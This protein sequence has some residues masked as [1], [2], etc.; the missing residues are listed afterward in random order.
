MD[1]DPT[2]TA[3]HPPLF[4][5]GFPWWAVMVLFMLVTGYFQNWVRNQFY[6]Y[7]SEL[8]AVAAEFAG[9]T[10]ADRTAWWAEHRAEQP[11]RYREMH[12]GAQAILDTWTLERIV[13]L[14]YALIFAFIGMF[15]ICDALFLR[16]CNARKQ[17]PF[18]KIIYVLVGATLF[19]L[20][21]LKAKYPGAHNLDGGLLPFLMS[22]MPSFVLVLF[23]WLL[24]RTHGK[25]I[26]SRT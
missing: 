20:T 19:F 25:E 18:L 16:V 17:I 10:D 11:F 8:P 13:V 6:W 14:D 22:P 21:I 15:F 24:R 1:S 9:W 12:A 2:R 3:P 4:P 26:A 7:K 5:P 23:P